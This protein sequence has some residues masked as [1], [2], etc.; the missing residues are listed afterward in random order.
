MERS[1]CIDSTG[2]ATIDREMVITQCLCKVDA[3]YTSSLKGK[4][5]TPNRK[6]AMGISGQ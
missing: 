4:Q 2:Y 5:S 6:N 3:V 1:Y